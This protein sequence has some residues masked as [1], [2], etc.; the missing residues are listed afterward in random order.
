MS[1]WPA[2]S[3]FSSVSCWFSSLSQALCTSGRESDCSPDTI[4][5]SSYQLLA[6]LMTSAW[7]HQHSRRSAMA[8]DARFLAPTYRLLFA[9]RSLNAHVQV[10]GWHNVQSFPPAVSSGRRVRLMKV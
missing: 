1:L 9:D 5:A 7:T 10:G 3:V 6:G 2:D 8:F 4:E